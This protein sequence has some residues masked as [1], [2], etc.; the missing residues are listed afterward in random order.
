MIDTFDTEV[1]AKRVH[2]RIAGERGDGGTPPV[3]FLHGAG[4]DGSVWDFQVEGVAAG[5]MW[6]MAV[7]FPG[8]GGSAGPGLHTIDGL[9]AW[10]ARFLDAVDAPR[11]HL[12]G[13]SLGALVVLDLAALD[14]GRVA[15]LALLG[16]AATMAVNPDLLAGAERNDGHTLEQMSQW[17]HAREPDGP[18]GWGSAETLALLERA[19]PGV[20][21]GDLAACDNHGDATAA[22]GDVEAPTL[23]VLGRQDVMT[24]PRGAAPLAE[25]LGDSRTVVIHGAGHMMMVEKPHEVNDALLGFIAGRAVPHG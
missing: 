8:H 22:T 1:D 20:V 6:G 2:V 14:P 4:V 7:D 25:T 18:T 17:M 13:S 5:G 19:E 21:F 11:A 12:V 3:V 16:V 15:S 9:A 23:L 10:T 24:R